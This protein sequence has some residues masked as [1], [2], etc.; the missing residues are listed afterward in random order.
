MTFLGIYCLVWGFPVV[1]GREW[2]CMSG[3]DDLGEEL[4]RLREEQ[5][6]SSQAELARRSHVS[7]SQI[8]LIEA[9][10]TGTK[11]ST[12]MLLARGLATDREGNVNG[13]RVEAIYGR[14][15]RAAGFYPKPR[16]EHDADDDGETWEAFRRRIALATGRTEV[17]LAADTVVGNYHR[18]PKRLKRVFEELLLEM[19][20]DITESRERAD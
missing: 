4:F 17:A 9:G 8:K 16:D 12:L 3:S 11:P 15:M 7:Q 20:E 1:A 13:K 6:I 10:K 18:A 19:A 5:G 2:E 14:L